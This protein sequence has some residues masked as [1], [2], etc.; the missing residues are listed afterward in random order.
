MVWYH[1]MDPAEKHSNATNDMIEL[2]QTLDI[3][4]E[5]STI[6]ARLLTNTLAACTIYERVPDAGLMTSHLTAQV[7]CLCSW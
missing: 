4:V 2:K 6:A 1:N 5:A 3:K 7:Q